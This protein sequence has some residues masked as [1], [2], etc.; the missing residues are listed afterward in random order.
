MI[1]ISNDMIKYIEQIKNSTREELVE[2]GLQSEESIVSYDN[3]ILSLYLSAT[4]LWITVAALGLVTWVWYVEYRTPLKMIIG[5]IA[6]LL[7]TR[8]VESIIT[9]RKLKKKGLTIEDISIV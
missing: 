5:L 9:R 6:L 3:K 1:S 4:N 7:L 8:I 2:K